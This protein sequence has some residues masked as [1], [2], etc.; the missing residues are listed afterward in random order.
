MGP[1]RK[2]QQWAVG[3]KIKKHFEDLGDF[4]G[5]VMSYQ[6]GLYSIVYPDGGKE[7]FNDKEMLR[8]AFKQE[9]HT[10]SRSATKAAQGLCENDSH[11]ESEEIGSVDNNNPNASNRDERMR[12]K[13]RMRR[14]IEAMHD[15]L[16]VTGYAKGHSGHKKRK[17]P[18]QVSKIRTE[19]RKELEKADAAELAVLGEPGSDSGG[20]DR[21]GD[22]NLVGGKRKRKKRLRGSMAALED[23]VLN[24]SLIFRPP[25]ARAMNDEDKEGGGDEEV[26]CEQEDDDGGDGDV[27]AETSHQASGHAEKRKSLTMQKQRSSRKKQTTVAA[28][29]RKKAPQTAKKRRQMYRLR[30]FQSFRMAQRHGEALAAHAQGQHKLAIEKLKAV[31]RD[32]PSAPQVYSSLGMVYEDMLKEC[33]GRYYYRKANGDEVVVAVNDV[34]TRKTEQHSG[35]PSSPPHIPNPFLREQCDLAKKAYGSHHVSAILCKK[36][37]TLWVRAADSALDIA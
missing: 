28:G 10:F 2:R 22:H 17:V 30:N 25:T 24:E 9:N 27:E 36:D 29:N 1:K 13:A 35:S 32:A 3:T 21:L 34:E 4:T 14:D 37:F 31:A 23:D 19:R 33:R 12:R 26:D 7:Q 18:R 5:E 16:E 6:N 11:R 8:Y 20:E 15:E